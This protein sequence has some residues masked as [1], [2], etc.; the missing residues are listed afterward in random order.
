MNN[1]NLFKLTPEQIKDEAVFEEIKNQG[2]DFVFHRDVRES[3]E[4]MKNFESIEKNN[5]RFKYQL[6]D[7][8]PVL[9]SQYLDLMVRLKLVALPLLSY[10][11]VA[12]FIEENFAKAMNDPDNDI[13]ERVETRLMV[14]PD[15]IRDDLRE[16]IYKALKRNE[17]KLGENRIIVK[18]EEEPQLPLIKNWLLD[19]DRTIGIEKHSN[20]EKAQY[21]SHNSNIARLSK[22]DKEKIHKLLRFYDAMKPITLQM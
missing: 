14:L 13:E 5:P 10:E 21:I 12:E 17:E 16:L 9:Y 6:R 7:E 20:I 4:L 1:I 8:K 18:R 3:F 15:V 2:E 19:Y 22:P 11:E